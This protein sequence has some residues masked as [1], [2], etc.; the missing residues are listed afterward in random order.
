M[1]RFASVFVPKRDR[2]KRLPVPSP[3]NTPQLSIA[4]DPAQSS[5]ASS[6]GS[7]SL[8]LHTPDDE[9]HLPIILNHQKRSWKYWIGR[10]RSLSLKHISSPLDPPAVPDWRAAPPLPQNHSEDE[11]FEPDDDDDASFSPLPVPP[12]PHDD[13]RAMQVLRILLANSLIPPQPPSPFVQHNLGPFFPRSTNH[14]SILSYHS[15]TRVSMFRKHL[16]VRLQRSDL[17]P[18]ELADI[19][20]LC[21]NQ[22]P[23]LLSPP[24]PSFPDSS[25]PSASSKL[26][27]ASPGLRHWI[28]RPCFEDRYLI[29]FPSESGVD[30]RH[31]ASSMAIAALEYSEHLDVMVDPDFDQSLLPENVLDT[32][33]PTEP[34]LTTTLS[35][36]PMAS[37]APVSAPAPV[38]SRNSYTATPSPLRN[39]HDPTPGPPPVVV[40]KSEELPNKR[41]SAIKGTVKRVV[42]FAEDDS[43]DATPLHIVRMKKKREEKANFL[44]Q[45]QARRA[46]EEE[47]ERRQREQELRR[48]EDEALERERRRLAIEREKK[49]REKAMYAE[50]VAA[51]RMRR[52]TYRA[53]GVPSSNTTTSN[54]LV[55]SPSFSSLRDSERNRAPPSDS[56]TYSRVSHNA[57]PSLSIPRGDASDPALH[58]NTPSSHAYNHFS[59]SPSPGSSRPPSLAHS[60]VSPGHGQHSRPPST[61]SAH[62]SSSEDVRHQSGSRRNSLAAS[63]A[64]PAYVLTPMIASY[65]TWSGSNPNIQ[66]VPPVPPFPDFVHDMPLLPPTAPFM[67]HEYKP[68][69]SSSSR[70]DSSPAR[71]SGS[72]RGSVNSSSERV[73]VVPKSMQ[74]SQS[75]SASPSS[76]NPS[77]SS[78]SSSRPRQSSGSSGSPAR[79]THERRGSGDSRNTSHT[80]RQPTHQLQQLQTP[81]RPSPMTSRSHPVVPRGRPEQPTRSQTQSQYIQASMNP[82]MTSMPVMMVPMS[83]QPASPYMNV[84]MYPAM[85]FNNGADLRSASMGRSSGGAGAGRGGGGAGQMSTII[86]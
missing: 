49:E 84:P 27:P 57:P 78:M 17:S 81:P 41:K 44:R 75:T 34:T 53:G 32:W 26:F 67:K 3:A 70:K 45:E 73:N 25:R 37:S 40:S 58:L 56:R 72:R 71:S 51:T 10:K 21:A 76:C 86:S 46:K 35:H 64:G 69:S 74:H 4:S 82:W 2:D 11:D 47:A 9:H 13:P 43:D 39:E 5:S 60:P 65:P 59:D 66:Y 33:L 22:T 80:H 77:S 30:C 1:R 15:D 55:P 61:Y 31:V 36:A 48:L 54:L 7:A 28:A 12:L 8:N 19:R 83:A 79:P 16:A 23:T 62:T 29:Y 68:R 24:H 6:S 50:T 42:R 14:R 20:P 63:A 85:P 38:H 18:S 52:E